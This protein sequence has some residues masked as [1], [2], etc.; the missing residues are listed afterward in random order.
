MYSVLDEPLGRNLVL[1]NGQDEIG[2]PDHPAVDEPRGRGKVLGVALRRAVVGPSQQRLAIAGRQAPVVG[3]LP[4]PRIRVPRRHVAVADFVAD[5]LGMRPRVVVGQQRHRA[6]LSGPVTSHAILVKDG[7]DIFAECRDRGAS[8]RGRAGAF[9][10]GLFRARA[11]ERGAEA[12]GRKGDRRA[13]LHRMPP[14]CCD[15]A[16]GTAGLKRSPACCLSSHVR[17]LHLTSVFGSGF[18]SFAS[19]GY[20]DSNAE[21]AAGRRNPLFDSRK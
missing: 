16:A 19:V 9:R 6:D 11:D 5:R 12:E 4:V 2:F 10:D 8:R 13:L 3:E 1:G 20:V 17:S 21:D 18:D 14:G 15:V 7:R